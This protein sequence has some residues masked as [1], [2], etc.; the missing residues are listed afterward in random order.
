MNYDFFE[1]HFIFIVPTF[2]AKE[3]CETK[4]EN[5][6]NDLVKLIKIRWSNLKFEIE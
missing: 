1:K 4:D 5:K 6:N 3:L 2:L